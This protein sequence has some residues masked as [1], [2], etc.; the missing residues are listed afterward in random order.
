MA[1]GL[2]QDLGEHDHQHGH[3]QRRVDHADVAEP[4]QQD[5]GGERRGGDVDDIVAEQQRADQPLAHG[6]Q[7]VDDGRPRGLPCFSSRSMRARDDAIS[8]VSL[9]AKKNESRRQR[10][11]ATS[12]SQSSSNI[13]QASFS[14]RKART[15]SASTSG[16]MKLSPTPRARMKV[17]LPRFT[18]L[19]WAISVHQLID[20]GF[21]SPGF[22]AAWVGRPTAARCA[23]TRSAS[24]GAE[25]AETRR[26]RK[27]QH[28]AERRPPRR[29][30]AGRRSPPR[31]RAH[32]RTCG[33][34]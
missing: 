17:S 3:H 4:D 32:G 11:T 30:A 10:R 7:A 33:R 26:E 23:A 1:I 27:G 15:S 34:D 13:V 20:A 18:F 16:A 19:S 22:R 5:A 8:A 21:R 29:A 14:A 31:P 12:A 9:P 25:Q 24:L 6:H 2:R 28:H